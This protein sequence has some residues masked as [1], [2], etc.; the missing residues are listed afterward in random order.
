[1]SEEDLA[2][3]TLRSA[4]DALALELDLELVEKCYAIQKSHQFSN[5]RSVSL[6]LMDR[7]IDGFV[8]KLMAEGSEGAAV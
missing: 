6:N 5:D 3:E 2:F 4:L 7:L 1:M 8:D